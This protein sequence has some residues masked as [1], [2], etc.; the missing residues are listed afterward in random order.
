M[1]V[2]VLTYPPMNTYSSPAG[3]N[4]STNAEYK[5][6]AGTRTKPAGTKPAGTTAAASKSKQQK[7]LVIRGKV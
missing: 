3:R 5:N 2:R 1:V 7:Q 4:V 6:L